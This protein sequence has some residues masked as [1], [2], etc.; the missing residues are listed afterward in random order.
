MSLSQIILV[1][2]H[3]KEKSQGTIDLQALD[4]RPVL[5]ISRHVQ[6]DAHSLGNGAAY[7]GRLRILKCSLNQP[8]P[9]I[10]DNDIWGMYVC[11]SV[12]L[13][14]CVCVYVCMYVCMYVYIYVSVC[15]YL[16]VC[17]YVYIYII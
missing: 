17:M 7:S 16:Y 8:Q 4:L 13:S 12:C 14:V 2:V 9:T 11:L 5:L 6:I 15:I 3:E 10:C 1:L